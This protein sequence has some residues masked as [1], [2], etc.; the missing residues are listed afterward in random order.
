MS[1]DNNGSPKNITLWYFYT[2]I[3]L[4]IVTG[5]I[6]TIANKLQNISVSLGEQYN[7]SYF[8]TF[9]MFLGESLCLI[10]YSFEKKTV[11][12]NSNKNTN[13]NNND[14]N[15]NE[16]ENE[17]PRD[18]NNTSNPNEIHETEILLQANQNNNKNNNNITINVNS[19]AN[20]NI[21]NT[22]AEKLEATPFM[23]ILPALCD[24]FASTIMTIGLTMLAGST[25]QMMRGSAIL[26][27]ALFSRIFLQSKL[28]SHHYIAL[29]AVISGLTLVGA[30]NVI[31]KPAFP[32][33]CGKAPEQSSSAAGYLLVILAQIFVAFQ[34][35][36]EEKF[37]KNYTCH[38]LKA[39]GWEGVWGSALFLVV[40]VIFQNVKCTNPVGD[41]WN[42][43]TA[44]CTKNDR[45]EFRLEDSFFAL[46]QIASNTQLLFYSVLFTISIAVFN[47]V[48]ITVTKIASSAARAVIDSVRTIVIWAFFM[49][50]II[51]VCHREHFNFIQL[52]G[53]L[54]LIFGTLVYNEIVELPFT[55]KKGQSQVQAQALAKGEG[56]ELEYG[57]DKESG[58]KFDKKNLGAAAT[59][60]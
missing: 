10:M 42:W 32:A 37:M 19:N 11:Q 44:L 27:T 13:K 9:L 7:H 53:F 21:E 35:I 36:I 3:L 48:G 33:G 20:E 39:V 12:N 23:L 22:V 15:E 18:I 57:E 5:S 28:H 54:F 55:Q 38:P 50:P 4:M 51:D 45:N 30:A 41:Q 2:F 40:L 47:F 43:S 59:V 60:A 1:S 49:M 56:D 26:F 17:I 58:N 34:F 6:N 29:A 46:R 8:I 25:Y 24:F 14:N 16:N 52:I 31:I